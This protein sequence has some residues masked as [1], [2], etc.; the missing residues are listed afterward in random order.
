MR[1]SGKLESL[2]LSY[3]EKIIW[4]VIGSTKQAKPRSIFRHEIIY[5]TYTHP[6][7]FLGIRNGLD[8]IT[9]Q[10]QCKGPHKPDLL[11]R[12]GHLPTRPYGLSQRDGDMLA[13]ELPISP[14]FLH[15]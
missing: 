5:K 3:H 13:P 10:N 9:Q 12:L 15:A 2:T 8:S 11:L 4:T 7:F 6:T 1:L 14:F